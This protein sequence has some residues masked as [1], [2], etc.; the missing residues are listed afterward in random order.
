MW[1]PQDE[2]AQ[3]LA[4]VITDISDGLSRHGDQLL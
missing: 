3:Q 1:S 4:M 2:V